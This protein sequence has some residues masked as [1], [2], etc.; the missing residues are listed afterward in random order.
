MIFSSPQKVLEHWIREKGTIANKIMGK[1]K[2]TQILIPLFKLLGMKGHCGFYSCK[3]VSASLPHLIFIYIHLSRKPK[4]EQNPIVPKKHN[5]SLLLLPLFVSA[6][7]ALCMLF[8]HSFQT[9]IRVKIEMCTLLGVCVV[10]RLRFQV[11][12][13]QLSSLQVNAGRRWAGGCS[14]SRFANA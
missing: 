12:D 7:F 5:A 13:S 8:H 4:M 6:A 9:G 3:G 2:A 11:S 14:S 1:H 10:H